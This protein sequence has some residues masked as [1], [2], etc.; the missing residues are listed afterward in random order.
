MKHITILLF[1]FYAF[2]ALGQK[3]ALN[4]SQLGKWPTVE[5]VGISNDGHYYYS[6]VND[7]SRLGLTLILTADASAGGRSIVVDGASYLT[8]SADSR[9]AIFLGP[10]DTLGIV[11]LHTF[12]T[13]YF[14][15]VA[16]FRVS[17]SCKMPC[18]VFLSATAERQLTLYY[19]A[20]RKS[21]TFAGVKAYVFAANGNRLAII[22]SIDSSQGAA[23]AVTVL[24]IPI[25]KDA[26]VWRG[27]S[28]GNLS[29]D[30]AGRQLAFIGTVGGT[31]SLYYFEDGQHGAI[32]WVDRHS[33][34]VP[35]EYGIADASLK[36]SEDG[37]RVLF[38]VEKPVQTRTSLV[39]GLR[40]VDVWTYKDPYLQSEQSSNPSYF[41]DLL[42]PSAFLAVAAV[43]QHRVIVTQRPSNEL[44]SN[45]AFNDLLYM[46]DEDPVKYRRS[47]EV[48]VGLSVLSTI[49]GNQMEL[50]PGAHIVYTTVS[51]QGRFLLWFDTDKLE[52]WCFDG[53]S[54][55]KTNMSALIPF[56]IYDEDAAAIGRRNGVFGIGGWSEGDATVLIYDQYDI[57][58]VDPTGQKPAV[59]LTGGQGRA[60]KTV[61]GVV[62]TGAEEV[63]MAEAIPKTISSNE[64]ILLTGINRKTKESGYFRVSDLEHHVLRKLCWAPACYYI[65]RIGATGN[66]EYPRYV[67]FPRKA[68]DA[69]SYLICSMT[70]KDYPNWSITSDFKTLTPVTNLH[71]EAGVNW[72]TSKLIN[73]QM[74]DGHFS[75]G[76][77]YRPENFDPTR[78]YPVIFD[79]YEKRSD[80]LHNYMMPDF[81]GSRIDIPYFVSNGYL[82]FVP[83]IYFKPG[84]NG[85]G[86]LN[87]VVSAARFLEQFPWV[88]STRFGLQGHSFG[89]W[90]TNYLITH[91]TLFKAACEV[92]GVSDQ[93][94]GYDELQFGRGAYR[95][96]IYEVV[97]QGSPYGLGI[98]PWTAS[99]EYIENSPVMYVD[100]VTTPLLIMQGDADRAVP[101]GQSVELFMALRRAAKKVWFLQYEK[102]GH[103]LSREADARDFTVRI[104]Q[105][106]DYYLMNAL[107]PKW[108]T[109]GVPLYKKG[110]ASGLELDLSGAVP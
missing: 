75:Q 46:K 66:V 29:F 4:T 44:V 3:P 57:W 93:I 41:R 62:N 103:I 22:H 67:N 55:K 7:P 89:G 59:C 74:T 98:T 61:L 102:E 10:K 56:P 68:K 26:L 30:P 69:D 95:Q 73:W 35:A 53:V 70:A 101:F 106:F 19:L 84:H 83:D 82:V 109:K 78:K 2:S 5:T 39:D 14:S 110:E 107:P 54:D 90:E 15:G 13:Q 99:Q 88:D 17:S 6:V 21:Q 1:I 37:K 11:D 87:A 91:S 85:D 48:K 43:G 27:E 9:W 20:S 86:T 79:Y 25:G 51:P 97:G 94:S 108:M 64:S 58:K 92:A 50:L 65:A 60:S 76:I 71:P 104:K 105:F 47:P 33:D 16:S 42:D 31:R 40:S 28:V 81:I 36:F 49:T 38:S 24:N 12:S 23:A 34:G 18:V 77:L 96:D 45:T 32:P 52:F 63:S 80:D 72:L 100:R 8:F